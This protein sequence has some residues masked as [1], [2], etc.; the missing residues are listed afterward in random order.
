MKISVGSYYR[1]G[2][3]FLKDF[4]NVLQKFDYHGKFIN[5][6]KFKVF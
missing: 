1:L 6:Q 5:I 2:I 3:R 4:G